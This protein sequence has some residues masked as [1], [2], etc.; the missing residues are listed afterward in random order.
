MSRLILNFSLGFLNTEG[1]GRN[2]LLL[3]AWRV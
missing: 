1:L 3:F 2:G